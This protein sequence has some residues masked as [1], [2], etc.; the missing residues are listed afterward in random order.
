MKVPDKIFVHKGPHLGL[1]TTTIIKTDAPDETEFIRKDDFLEW[2]KEH[3][4]GLDITKR[5]MWDGGYN[6]AMK[7]LIEKLNSM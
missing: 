6:C 2:A 7:Q 3:Y 1:I 4:T 5:D